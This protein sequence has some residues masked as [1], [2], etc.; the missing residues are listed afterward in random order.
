MSGLMAIL[1]NSIS[2]YQWLLGT[3]SD[4]EVEAS[5]SMS[6]SLVADM[7]PLQQDIT[8]ALGT[9]QVA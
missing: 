7:Y 6:V 3:T 2:D 4:S 8:V 1:V 5:G 9:S